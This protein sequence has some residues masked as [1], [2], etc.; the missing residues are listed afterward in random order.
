MCRSLIVY[1]ILCINTHISIE[2]Y[3]KFVGQQCKFTS[4]LLHTNS[5]TSNTITKHVNNTGW[6]RGK[7]LV[8]GTDRR[9]GKGSAISSHCLPVFTTNSPSQEKT[10]WRAQR[11]G[12]Y[13]ICLLLCLNG[14]FE[15]LPHSSSQS[16]MGVWTERTPYFYSHALCSLVLSYS[17]SSENT[18][19]WALGKPMGVL[20]MALTRLGFQPPG[21]KTDTGTK[22]FLPYQGDRTIHQD[23]EFP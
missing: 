13:C 16:N 6:W 3:S 22:H 14:K 23:S 5:S 11:E 21:N 10:N 4:V 7:L 1:T 2:I 18:D 19:S 12:K 15:L 8:W 20:L 17:N 9:R